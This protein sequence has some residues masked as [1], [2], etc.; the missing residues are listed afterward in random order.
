MKHWETQTNA[1][2]ACI[3]R[4]GVCLSREVPRPRRGIALKSSWAIDGQK[5]VERKT[6]D[7]EAEATVTRRGRRARGGGEEQRWQKLES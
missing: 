5:G 7:Q 1:P 6:S 3:E 2:T 4:S